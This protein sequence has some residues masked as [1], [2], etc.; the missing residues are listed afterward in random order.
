MAAE[1]ESYNKPGYDGR[2]E[3]YKHL[4]D[5]WDGLSNSALSGDLDIW[6]RYLRGYF[7]RTREFIRPKLREE[8]SKKF[9]ILNQLNLKLNLGG[10]MGQVDKF[11]LENKM[12]N[13]IQLLEDDLFS[14]TKALLLPMKAEEEEEWDIQQF[15]RESDL[16]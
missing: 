5:Y 15:L 14:G 7:A 10:A 2:L 13:T 1:E 3:F 12:I 6:I 9:V 11:I 16:A 8:I 4:K